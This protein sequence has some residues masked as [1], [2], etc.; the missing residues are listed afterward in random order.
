MIKVFGWMQKKGRSVE[1]S[2]Q[3]LSQWCQHWI[4]LAPKSANASAS[5][6]DTASAPALVSSPPFAGPP[7][8]AASASDAG[9]EKQS[10]VSF[11]D[12]NDA[13]MWKTAFIELTLGWARY[14]YQVN[15]VYQ[16]KINQLTTKLANSSETCQEERTTA[17][18]LVDEL[19][20]ERMGLIGIIEDTE[21]RLRKILPEHVV[22]SW[23]KLFYSV[24]TNVPEVETKL[25]P[26]GDEW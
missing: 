23:V 11:N 14:C 9:N 7:P 1:V 12:E 21:A 18:R 26:T 4:D 6:P 17:N 3:T 25:V 8:V 10:S 24:F 22:N 16:V 20:K 19:H 15:Y 13:T 2:K 5:A